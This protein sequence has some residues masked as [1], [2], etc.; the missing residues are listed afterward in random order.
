[1]LDNITTS[2]LVELHNTVAQ[3]LRGIKPLGTYKG[4]KQALFEKLDSLQALTPKHIADLLGGA[5]PY[6]VRQKLRLAREQNLI[7]DHAWHKQYLLSPIQFAK[8][9]GV[10]H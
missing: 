10:F 7:T 9:F 6:N 4:S 2:Q 3:V 8:V 5:N 1:M